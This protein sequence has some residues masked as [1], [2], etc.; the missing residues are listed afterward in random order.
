MSSNARLRAQILQSSFHASIRPASSVYKQG[1]QA[2]FGKHTSLL[3]PLSRKG[4]AR[5]SALGL[6]GRIRC[7]DPSAPPSLT[8]RH[9]CRARLPPLSL[10]CAHCSGEFCPLFHTFRL[11][12]RRAHK[13]RLPSP[14][15]ST[16][17]KKLA[18]PHR[19]SSGG[20]IPRSTSSRPRVTVSRF[21]ITT[22][23]AGLTSYWSMELA[24]KA[25]PRAKDRA[26]VS[27]TT[28]TTERSPT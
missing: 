21:S 16:S 14:T 20:S 6:V 12:T 8:S 25:S 17:Q 22:T 9:P 5:A 15:L 3:V 28:T 19:T 11:N 4:C 18:S 7:L 1:G 27:I 10:P 24:W 13:S 23:M 2:E 26:T